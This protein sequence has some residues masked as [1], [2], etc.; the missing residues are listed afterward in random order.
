MVKYPKK[1]PNASKS[2]TKANAA[3]KS[4]STGPKRPVKVAEDV[5][6]SPDP[7][8]VRRLDREAAQE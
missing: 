3:A 7:R 6:Y 1:S 8:E 5:D 4:N 2:K